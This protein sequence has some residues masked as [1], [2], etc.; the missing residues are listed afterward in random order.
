MDLHFGFLPL[1]QQITYNTYEAKFEILLI[2]RFVLIF[3]LI[4]TSFYVITSMETKHVRI[5]AKDAFRYIFCHI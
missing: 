2:G 1:L 3:P 4:S 5:S